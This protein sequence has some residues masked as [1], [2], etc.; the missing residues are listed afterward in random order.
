MLG[1]VG[2]AEFPTCLAPRIHHAKLIKSK[3][4]FA[5]QCRA[6]I[7]RCCIGALLQ[8]HPTTIGKETQYDDKV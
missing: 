3:V 7:R 5:F 8:L 4:P 1:H 6:C 2:D